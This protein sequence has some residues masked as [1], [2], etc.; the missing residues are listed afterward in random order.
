[1]HSL[2]NTL[3]QSFTK[4]IHL[5][6]PELDREIIA[7]ITVSTQEN[8]GH[9]QCNSAL[10]LSKTVG[11]PP[12]IVAE[13]IISTFKGLPIGEETHCEVAGPGFINIRL[14]PSFLA[15]L[16]DKRLTDPRLGIAIN[17]QNEKIVIDFS[18]PNTAKEMHVGH[19]RST[20]IGDCLARLFEFLGYDVLRLNHIG[21][22]GTA[23]GMLITYMQ[24]TAKPV[25]THDS[26]VTATELVEFYKASKQQF[27]HDP[28]FKKRAQLAVVKLQNEDPDLIRAWH[29]ICNISN[30]AN[31]EIYDLLDVKITN[32]GESFYNPFLKTLIEDLEKKG[33]IE[34]SDGA[35]CIFLEGFKN[36]QG[37]YLP[38]MLQKSDGGFNYATTDLAALKH[39]IDIEKAN[40]L[41]YVTDA[42]Q[43]VHF[44]M[45]FKAAEKIGYLDPQQVRCDHVPFG[46]VL[47]P[48]GK[49]FKTRSGDT[50]RLIDLLD[51]A[52][53]KAR[54][55]LQERDNT[56]TG[57]ELE[58]TAKIL[59]INAIKYAD[60]SCH[61]TSDYVF[62]YERMLQFEGN[63]AT[64]LMYSYV[65]TLSIQRKV[66]ISIDEIKKSTAI[67]LEHSTE[68]QLALHLNRFNETL[69]V[70]AQDLLP[71]HLTDYLYQL[72]NYFNA[73]F[74]DC[75]VE[76][77]ELQNSRL[78]LCDLT[79]KTLQ[80][81]FDLLGLKLLTRM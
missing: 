38:F 49:K 64:F 48:D 42:G 57:K 27:D 50:E 68:I 10:K 26:T 34:I 61:R 76:G 36:R 46:L 32:R 9:Y 67:H 13:N 33:F 52:I 47:G 63:T 74:R 28:E 58:E 59:G 19:L 37:E 25:L 4:A 43:I 21:D 15:A 80:K 78:L 14:N 62:S 60:L 73:F 20:I 17:H 29:S 24:E 12:R 40:R 71:H 77:S 2:I 7:E 55:I 65:R 31:Q 81:G 70:V 79:A 18:S 41:I 16:L 5:A 75:R 23:F 22:W 11:L 45:L 66:G 39:R 30:K 8:F 44:Q 51:A 1:M 3:G 35:K 69:Q 72:A 56:L 53:E 54:V 6:F